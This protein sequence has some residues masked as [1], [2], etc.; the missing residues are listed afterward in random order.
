[1]KL[2]KAIEFVVAHENFIRFLDERR[3]KPDS[4]HSIL[5]KLTKST[6]EVVEHRI[7]FDFGARGE[8]PSDIRV[9]VDYDKISNSFLFIQIDN[10][11]RL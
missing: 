10:P 4:A 2:L 1:M 3:I 7:Y 11:L 6:N 5:G 9:I 8:S